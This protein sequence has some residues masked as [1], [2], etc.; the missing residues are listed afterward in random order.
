M[1]VNITSLL[2]EFSLFFSCAKKNPMYSKLY[3]TV[4]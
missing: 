2:K 4:S 3:S 1:S